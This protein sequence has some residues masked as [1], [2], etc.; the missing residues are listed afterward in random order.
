M[1]TAALPEDTGTRQEGKL[2]DVVLNTLVWPVS[3]TPKDR[4]TPPSPVWHQGGYQ[5]QAETWPSSLTG[6]TSTNC[7]HA[8]FS[9]PPQTLP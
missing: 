2:P 5:N 7:C 9:L 8:K 4:G 3:T 6:Y 1:S